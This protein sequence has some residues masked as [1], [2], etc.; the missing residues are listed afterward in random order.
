MPRRGTSSIQ[1]LVRISFIVVFIYGYYTYNELK[2]AFRR[3]EESVK[4]MKLQEENLSAQLQGN[5]LI[6]VCVSRFCVDV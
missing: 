2:S 6:A 4:R 3:S 5:H 1:I